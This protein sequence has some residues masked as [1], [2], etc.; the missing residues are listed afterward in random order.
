MRPH[1]Y[2]LN[3]HEPVPADDLLAWA[4]WFEGS[5]GERRVAETTVGD[6]RVSTV[7]LGL[8]HDHLGIKQHAHA[9][10]RVNASLT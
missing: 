10:A 2:T 1:Q 9:V 3:G 7:F 4:T 6:A 8:D 5:V